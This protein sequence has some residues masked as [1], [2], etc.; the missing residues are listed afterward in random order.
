M[1]CLEMLAWPNI[2]EVATEPA[3]LTQMSR[4]VAVVL[5]GSATLSVLARL[6][7]SRPSTKNRPKGSVPVQYFTVNGSKT[8]P[9][10]G[11]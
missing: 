9:T 6:F 1:H 11:K 5:F 2:S 7:P 3:P 8:E 10:K 4:H